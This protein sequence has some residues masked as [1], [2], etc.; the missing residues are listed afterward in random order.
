MTQLSTLPRRPRRRNEEDSFDMNPGH[1]VGPAVVS[2]VIDHQ[3]KTL[4]ARPEAAGSVP[5][6]MLWGPPGVGK[7]SLVR[8]A[9]E[10]HGIGFIDIRLSQRDPVDIRGLP[11]PRDGVVDWLLSSDWPRDKDSRGIILFDEL[12]AADRALQVAVYEILLDRRLGSLY[13]LPSGWYLMGAGNRGEDRAVATGF[14][15]ALANRFLHLELAARLDDWLRWAQAAGIHPTVTGFLRYRPDALHDMKGDLERGWPSPRSWERV[16]E[17]LHGAKGLPTEAETAMIHGLIGP[18]T[19]REF[20]AFRRVADEL[21]DV[22]AMLDGEIDVTLPQGAD[23]VYAFCASVLHHLWRGGQT[24]TR[25]DGFFRI[26]EALGSDFATLL[27]MDAISHPDREEADRRTE[28]L[29]GHPQFEAW[30]RQHGQPFEADA[31]GSLEG[32]Q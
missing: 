16:S 3:L 21:P 17:L 12:T 20:V 25:L 6:T 22:E 31:T 18:G 9:C 10:R 30:T 4:W 5:P 14:S 8:E 32:W 19:G 27:L 26:N 29:M 28:K 7:S 15:S 1:T 13:E 24:D 23:R 2:Q 11:V